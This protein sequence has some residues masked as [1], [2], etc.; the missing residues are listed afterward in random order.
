VKPRL[1]SYGRKEIFHKGR[2]RARAALS[3]KEERKRLSLLRKG[4]NRSYKESLMKEEG[5]KQ[6]REEIGLYSQDRA[7][8]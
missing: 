3:Q 8:L 4:K 7:P 2:R 6:P 1:F 5:E